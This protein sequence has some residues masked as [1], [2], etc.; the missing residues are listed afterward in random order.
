M[1]GAGPSLL[2]RDWLNAIRLDWSYVKLVQSTPAIKCQEV[3]DR[4]PSVVKDELGQIKGSSADFEVDPDAQPRFCRA[5]PVPYSLRS[6]VENELDRLVKNNVITPVTFSKWAAP[7]VPVLKRD[8]KVRICGDYKLT[9][10][11][12]TKTDPYPLTRIEDLFASLAK[13]HSFTKLD[14]AN[15]YQQIPLSDEGKELTTINTHKGLYQYN[16]LPFG[17][18]TAPAIFQ[19]TMDS[20]LQGLPH[21]CVYLDDL[22]ITGP[23]DEEHLKNLD[24]VLSKLHEA[25]VRLKLDKCAF[26]LPEVEYLGHII[27]ASGLH[28]SQEKVKALKEA[29]TP[30][31]VSQ[32]KSFLGLLNF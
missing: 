8:G 24:T 17:V 3:I 18:A 31:N 26:M 1:E 13:G 20:L 11:Q 32:L 5:R 15:A 23:T 14:L 4:Y 30:A 7:I 25:G 19:R 9:V 27:S 10:N 29:P 21:V 22:L 6:K 12:A 2:G 16:C 28:P